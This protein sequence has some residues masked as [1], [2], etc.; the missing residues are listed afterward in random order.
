MMIA[1]L[2]IIVIVFITKETLIVNLCEEMKLVC[3][4][5]CRVI[6]VIIIVF[7]SNAGRYQQ[8]Q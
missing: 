6:V 5:R 4:S 7:V 3:T 1:R 8:L 2:F